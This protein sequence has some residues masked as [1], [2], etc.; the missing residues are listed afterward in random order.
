MRT[1]YRDAFSQPEFDALVIR[2]RMTVPGNLKQLAYDV[3]ET[4]VQH[5]LGTSAAGWQI[6][7][8]P[9][10]P[11]YFDLIPPPEQHVSVKE[12]FDLKNTLK[13]EPSLEYV[14]ALFETNLDNLPEESFLGEDAE[15]LVDLASPWEKLTVT[16]RNP[17]WNHELVNTKVAWELSRGRGIIV[18]HP[19]SGYIPHFELD[20]DRI[21]HDLE[22]NFYDSAPGANNSDERGGNHGLG[23]ATVLMSGIGQQSDTHFV[24][25]IAPEA[26]LVP[27]R[28]TRKGAPIFFS[29]SGPRRVRN[30]IR[31]AIDSGCHVISMSLGGP[32]EK[33]L[34]EAI[35]EA[36]EKNIIVCAAAG[37]VVRFVV[38][39][40]HYEEVIAV[41]ACTAERQK[42]FHSSRGPTVDVTAPGHNVWRAYIDEF[43][44]A[45]S[46]PGSGTSYAT[47]HVA[48]IAALW[49]ARHGRDELLKK[50]QRMPLYRVF[51]EVLKAACDAPPEGDRGEFGAGI[52]NA[53]RTLT[54]EL[55][56][57][58]ELIAR[59]LEAPFQEGLPEA[60][61][62]ELDYFNTIFDT[63]PKADV[64]Q[65]LAVLLDVPEADLEARLQ[66]LNTEE[67][68]F[69]L[70]TDPDLREFFTGWELVEAEL[71][72]ASG[73][74][75]K[76]IV[77]DAQIR[78]QALHEKLMN[79]PLSDELRAQLTAVSE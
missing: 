51:R 41:A 28:I 23:T 22:G 20:D 56:D 4:A 13:K 52:V 29:R 2:F 66:M 7:P 58:N 64:R 54:A 45:S 74:E 71:A 55:P 1:L 32:F 59:F 38:W 73:L 78:G 37:N 63:L 47:P 31:H 39:P 75:G 36:V 40:A 3:L 15:S 42:W 67:L 9:G 43:G 77:P 76:V 62:T 48:G 57:E 18:G 68:A 72:E 46:L 49:L 34:H 33:S 8:V 16:E 11:A 70:M 61:P 27:M 50:Y 69:Y 25:G 79:A 44:N 6:N 5:I 26:I 65:R 35:Q 17:W 10:M 53:A 14:E 60:A 24:I 21:R 12:G 30:A 19:D